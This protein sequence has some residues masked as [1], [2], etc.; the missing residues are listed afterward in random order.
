MFG[1]DW[2][3]NLPSIVGAIVNLLVLV[4]VIKINGKVS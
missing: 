3:V 4:G 1:A 2:L